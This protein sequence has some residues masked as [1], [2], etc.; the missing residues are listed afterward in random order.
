MSTELDDKKRQEEE[1]AEKARKE[2]EHAEKVKKMFSKTLRGVEIFASGTWKGDKYTTQD[3]DAMVSAFYSLPYKV[4]VKLGHD[5]AQRWFGQADGY[6][7]LGWAENARRVGSKLVVDLEG[8][9]DA[10]HSMI[11]EKRY[12][13]VSAE[14]FWDYKT[15]DGQVW[16]RALKAVSLLGADLPAVSGLA[17]IQQALMSDTNRAVRVYDSTVAGQ[18]VTF[19]ASD[20]GTWTCYDVSRFGPSGGKTMDEKKY[21]ERIATLEGEVSSEKKRADAAEE[22][23]L[24]A[25]AT[26]AGRDE[27]HAVKHF[28]EVVLKGLK[29]EG[30]ILPAEEP[31]LINTFRAM[32]AGVKKYGEKEINPR[33]DFVKMLSAR[34]KQVDFTERGKGGETEE[35]SPAAEIDQK[36]R[37]FMDAHPNKTYRDGI[38]S[39]RKAEPDLWNRYVKG[40]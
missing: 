19:G 40:E 10:L 30:K 8:V 37:K 1:A 7:A 39:V 29:A 9:P 25:E 2:Q 18:T 26:L 4:P 33:E 28:T 32:G 24:K 27:E 14:V 3:L 31:T 5:E 36:V 34:P 35:K 16:P 15:D 17:D 22:R 38:E 21:T 11:G 13:K 23:A 6:P 20:T 12:R